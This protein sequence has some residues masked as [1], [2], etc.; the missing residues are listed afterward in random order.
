MRDIAIVERNPWLRG[1]GVGFRALCPHTLE[2]CPYP[3][4]EVSGATVASRLSRR[5]MGTNENRAG[6]LDTGA[7]GYQ[8][9]IRGKRQPDGCPPARLTCRFLPE[10]G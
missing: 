4:I 8:A 3:S 6:G 5:P 7:S 2:R 1:L 9:F 10:Y